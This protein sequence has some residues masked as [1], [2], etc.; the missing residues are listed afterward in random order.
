MNSKE[1]T[2][3]YLTERQCISI[4]H[5]F[6]SGGRVRYGQAFF[7]ALPEE[8]QNKIRGTVWDTFESD[9]PF[10]CALAIMNVL[11]V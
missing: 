5:A 3:W 10:D 1:M 7:N 4:F 11:T 9:S 8:D 6:L 2:E